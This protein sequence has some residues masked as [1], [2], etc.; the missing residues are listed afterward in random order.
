MNTFIEYLKRRR[1]SYLARRFGIECDGLD[2]L[3]FGRNTFFFARDILRIG[4]QVYIGRNSTI[5]TDAV[6]S[7]AVIMGN[8]VAFIGRHDHA[9]DEVGIP[10]RLGTSVR[11]ARFSVPLEKRLI[12]VERDV[13]I[14]YGSIV[15]S[16]VSIGEGTVVAA[17]SIVTRSIPSN[18]VVAG[19]P[20]RPLRARFDPLKFSTHCS[21]L[22][23]KGIRTLRPPEH[24]EFPA[25]A[26]QRERKFW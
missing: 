6:I 5:E 7:D 22:D 13:W 11:D 26:I 23:S 4:R 10:S 9:I 20:A 18:S 21:I 19:Q 24:G 2:T 12:H 15:L 3:T 25:S 14:G 8:N 17:G 1:I 16:G